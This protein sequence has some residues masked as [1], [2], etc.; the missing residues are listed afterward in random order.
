MIL[1]IHGKREGRNM[2]VGDPQHKASEGREVAALHLYLRPWV[3][4]APMLNHPSYTMS[5]GPFV[6]LSPC[7]SYKDFREERQLRNPDYSQEN[8]WC[9]CLQDSSNLLTSYLKNTVG[10]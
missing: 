9:V 7:D 3:L 4:A 5:L 8:K 10:L 2:G 6:E 1:Q